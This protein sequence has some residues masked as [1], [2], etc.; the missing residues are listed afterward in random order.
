MEFY[1]RIL[2]SNALNNTIHLIYELQHQIFNNVACATSK[3]SDKPAQSAQSPCLSLE[4]SL[5]VKLLTEHDFEFLCLEGGCTG[6]SESTLVKM[7]RC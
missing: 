4:Y 6:S 7:P 1:N 3:D 2:Q 5:T